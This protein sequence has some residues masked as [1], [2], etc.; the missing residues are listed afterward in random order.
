LSADRIA[1]DNLVT[2][3]AI[4]NVGV[5]EATEQ[6]YVNAVGDGFTVLKA[7]AGENAQAVKD[8]AIAEAIISAIL[9]AQQA[10]TSLSVIPVVG[11][12]LGAIAAAAA[13]ASGFANVRKIE[14]TKIPR[15]F[16]GTEY[17]GLNGNPDGK[18]TIP[19]YLNKGERIVPTEI[20]KALAGVSNPELPSLVMA[21]KMAKAHSFDRMIAQQ[22]KTN[23]L[24]GRFKYID[25]RG[26][27]ISLDGNTIGLG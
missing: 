11:T 3:N 16:K 4:N 27:L 25:H 7:L 6:D 17:L 2:E 13:L 9:G 24:L 18:D 12:A 5:R 15:L 10:F 22:S 8:V 26:N 21:G 1:T 23:A 19:A 20:N 14:N